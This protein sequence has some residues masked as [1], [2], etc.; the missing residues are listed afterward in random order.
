MV[1]GTAVKL[2]ASSQDPIHSVNALLPVDIAAQLPPLH[3]SAEH[4]NSIGRVKFYTSWAGWAWYASEYD[5]ERQLCYGIVCGLRREYGYFSVAE[6]EQFRGPYEF[7][8]KRDAH[9]SPR[10]L[11]D[12]R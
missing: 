10:P 9:W 1:L 6:L 8:V 7:R 5:P 3:G 11:K 2:P 12:C 4:P